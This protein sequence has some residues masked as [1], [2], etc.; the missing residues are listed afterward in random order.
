M[1]ASLNKSTATRL[2]GCCLLLAASILAPPSFADYAKHPEASDFINT[3]VI[4]HQFEREQVTK[5]LAAAKYQESIVKAMS[6]PAEKAKPWHEYGDFKAAGHPLSRL[7]D[8]IERRW[9]D[10]YQAHQSAP[11]IS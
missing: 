4:D 5:W 9:K 1:K 2:V 11:L 3:M 8:I 10:I 6:R 7:I